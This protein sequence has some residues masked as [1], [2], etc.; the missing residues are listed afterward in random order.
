MFGLSWFSTACYAVLGL[1]LFGVT[2]YALDTHARALKADQLE[3]TLKA[4]R[5]ATAKRDTIAIA[6]ASDAVTIA[7][8]LAEDTRAAIAA[9]TERLGR[10]RNVVQDPGGVCLD[11]DTVRLLNNRT[12][13]P[14]AVPRPAH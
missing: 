9:Q 7:R 4:E 2:Y 5:A 14:D 12:A 8:R 6:A 1:V 10:I 3:A 13:G 11:A